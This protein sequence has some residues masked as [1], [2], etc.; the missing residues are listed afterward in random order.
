[1]L[2]KTNLQGQVK[3]AQQWRKFCEIPYVQMN[4]Y[5]GSLPLVE[6]SGT[7]LK[8]VF[9]FFRFPSCC[10]V[11]EKSSPGAVTM[12]IIPC[13]G[14][15]CVDLKSATEMMLNLLFNVMS[16]LQVEKIT[17]ECGHYV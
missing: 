5:K 2:I 7:G 10:E 11:S 16:G 17:F 3:A 1:L 13:I 9:F 15:T 12:E 4:D 8:N 14:I 6:C